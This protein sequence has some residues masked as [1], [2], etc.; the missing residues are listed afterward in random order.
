MVAIA[1]GRM[2]SASMVFREGWGYLL[3]QMIEPLLRVFMRASRVQSR[4]I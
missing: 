1:T 4:A 3:V 2:G